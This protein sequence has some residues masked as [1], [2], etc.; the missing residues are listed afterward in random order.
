MF[1]DKSTQ[2]LHTVWRHSIPSVWSQRP[3]PNNSVSTS[4]PN[5]NFS[6]QPASTRMDGKTDIRSVSDRVFLEKATGN[7]I[8]CGASRAGMGLSLRCLRLRG[9]V[10][11]G[12]P[13]GSRRTVHLI[14][15][16]KS[17][18][19]SVDAIRKLI[20]TYCALSNLYHFYSLYSPRKY[21]PSLKPGHL[22]QSHN[23][24]NDSQSG[25]RLYPSASNSHAAP[26]AQSIFRVMKEASL[27]FCLPDSPFFLLNDESGHAVREA[28]YTCT[29]PPQKIK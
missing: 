16:G 28:A 24:Q 2:P 20:S 9:R 3:H 23:Y 6:N 17:N 8:L 22:T 15:S 11:G 10:R 5:A 29:F 25:L 21:S 18:Y 4:S 13:S 1:L 14:F 26:I 19:H 12:W 7:T 27:R